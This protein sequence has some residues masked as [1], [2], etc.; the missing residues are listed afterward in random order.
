MRCVRCF[1]YYFQI[2]YYNIITRGVGVKTGFVWTNLAR[3]SSNGRNGGAMNIL[4]HL[5]KSSNAN[6]TFM[7]YVNKKNPSNGLIKKSFAC[8][9][10]IQYYKYPN[11]MIRIRSSHTRHLYTNDKYICSHFRNFSHSWMPKKR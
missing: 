3:R 11:A 9:C 2:L 1:W 4:I 8:V 7:A 6:M 10:R 5:F